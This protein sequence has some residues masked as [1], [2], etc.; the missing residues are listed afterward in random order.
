MPHTPAAPDSDLTDADALLNEACERNAVI[1]LH[2]RDNNESIPAARGRMLAVRDDALV[3]AEPQIIGRDSRLSAGVAVDAFF[4]AG[5]VMLH[6]V[7]EIIST[8]EMVRL[9][10]H[11]R[12]RA[13]TISAPEAIAPGQRRSYFR[14]LVLG[15]E[16]V[17]A[18]LRAV[19]SADPIQCPIDAAP[20][21]AE[22]VD[23]SPLGF[24]LNVHESD[25]RRVR[26]YDLFFMSFTIP[27]DQQ[28]RTLLV[29]LRQNRDLGDTGLRRFGMLTHAW[30]TRRDHNLTI[31]PVLR[32]LHE[33][34]RR[35]LRAA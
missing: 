18:T 33:V 24:G 12:V 11:K 34:Q 26:L 17:R 27:G 16:P 9:N 19:L 31:Q 23:G 22:M 29:E 3:I 8:T 1:E 10:E 28:M 6:F 32:W 7:S 4:L 15:D 25:A 30:P 35:R 21:A 13:F 20:I 5:D 14:T 2:R